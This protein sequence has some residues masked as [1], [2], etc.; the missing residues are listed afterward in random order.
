MITQQ[1]GKG[2]RTALD[3]MLE[4]KNLSVHYETPKGDVIAANDVS[5]KVCCGEI[6]G[7]VG[8]SG[9]GKTTV[10]MAILQMVQ[11]PGR[12]RSSPPAYPGPG[13]QCRADAPGYP[14]AVR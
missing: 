13:S 4:V 5:F 1:D 7:L 11:S 10:A 8:E 14:G 6:L 12:R 9:C 3:V 2:A